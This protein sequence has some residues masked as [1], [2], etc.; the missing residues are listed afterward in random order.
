MTKKDVKKFEAMRQA[1]KI[2]SAALQKT[3]EAVSPGVTLEKLDKIAEDTILSLGATS[4]FKRVPD[5]DFTTCINVNEGLVHGL[6]TD[7]ALRPG[8]LVS[9]DLGAYYAGYN[10]DQCWTVEVETQKE[11]SFLS[12]GKKALQNAIKNAQVGN[13]IGDISHAIQETIE[14][15]GYTVSRELIGHGVGK[16][17]H[18]P[19]HVPGYGKPRKGPRLSEGMTLAI[20]VIYQ[21]GDYPIVIARDGWTVETADKSLAAVFEHSVGITKEGPVIFT[22]FKDFG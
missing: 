12:V 17:L 18:Q 22:D 15:K 20:E 5:Y 13:K 8:D 4:A 9:I 3:L 19:P 1:G 16:K 7:Y 6:P 2:S 14:A 21:K 11:S 10:S